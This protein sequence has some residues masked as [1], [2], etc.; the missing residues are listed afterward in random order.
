MPT[1]W[2]EKGVGFSLKLGSKPTNKKAVIDERNGSIGGYTTEHWDD[3]QDAEVL[4]KT[5]RAS[6]RVNNEEE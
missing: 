2:Q 3:H 1:K 4:A 6:L 5:V